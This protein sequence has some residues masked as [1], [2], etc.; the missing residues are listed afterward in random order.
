M[1]Q[2][3]HQINRILADNGLLCQ[4]TK[5]RD[6]Q[7]VARLVRAMEPGY[8]GNFQT[9]ERCA[10]R[11]F[12]LAISIAAYTENSKSAQ[13]TIERADLLQKKM[14]AALTALAR[15]ITAL[16]DTVKI[17]QKAGI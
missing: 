16:E 7:Y 15:R 8:S 13:R 17:Q 10:P 3:D 12:K 11:L 9:R 6:V 2:I 1:V 4:C 14:A 5:V